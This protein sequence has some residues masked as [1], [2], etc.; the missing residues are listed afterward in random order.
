MK[1]VILG[2]SGFLG[3]NLSGVFPTS[4]GLSLRNATWRDNVLN[5]TDILINLVGKAHDHKGEAKEEDFYYANFE[6]T[7]QVFEA[8]IDSPAKLLIHISSIAAVEEVGATDE[9]IEGSSCKPESWYGKSK[10][11]AEQ[12]LLEQRLPQD[13]KLIILRPPMVHGMGDK[14]SLGL[15]Y[16]LIS[17]GIPYPLAAFNNKR[18]FISIDNFTFLIKEIIKNHDR[19]T[20]GIYHI[21]DDEPIATKKIIQIIKKTTGKNVINLS[22]PRFF[23]RGIAK[24]GDIIPI[25]LNS[26]RLKKMTS[27]L[28]VSNEKI[29]KVLDVQHLPLSAEEGMIKTIRSFSSE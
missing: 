13:K 16:N 2:S 18:S 1:V 3:R 28:L 24:V 25:P 26:K 27:D 22:L 15:L 4:R 23:V 14:G 6:L 5:G 17:K 21:A 19:L 7:K 8:F 11:E 20:S 12:W 9:L 29:K 10:R